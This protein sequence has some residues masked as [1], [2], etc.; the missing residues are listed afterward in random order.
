MNE[1]IDNSK[2]EKQQDKAQRRRERELADIRLI[3]KSP[4]GRRFYWRVL[5]SG[6]VYNTQ[7]IESTNRTYF[8][9]GRKS[10]A[11]DFLSD[12]LDAKPTAFAEMQQEYA[13]EKKREDNEVKEEIKESDPLSLS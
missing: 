3:L 12:L 9:N 7:F 1:L 5:E 2:Q 10:V 4:E 13:S 8:E 6:R 11:G